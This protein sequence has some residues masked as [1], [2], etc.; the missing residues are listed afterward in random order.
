MFVKQK[1]S[2]LSHCD[3]ALEKY[4]SHTYFL[5][6]NKNLFYILFQIY[7]SEVV[8]AKTR[9]ACL[10]FVETI[11]VSGILFMFGLGAIPNFPYYKIALIPIGISALFIVTFMWIPESPRWLLL[12]CCDRSQA[13]SVLKYIH[14]PQ[15]K[16]EIE[17]ILGD[18]ETSATERT[19][20]FR[21]FRLLFCQ[22]QMLVP[23]IIALI[24]VAMQQ[25]CGIG[26][27]V[28]Y[29][30]QIFRRAGDQN[31]NF[32]AFFSAGLLFPL[33]TI[34]VVF[35]VEF[36]GRKLLLIASTAG[37]CVASLML[38]FQYYFTRPSLCLN[39]TTLEILEL[40]N[41]EMYCNPHL[42]PLSV[43]SVVLFS[44]SFEFGVGPMA[45]VIFSEYVPMQVKGLAGGIILAANR[46]AG[47]ILTGTYFTFSM[48]AGDYVVWWMLA[49]INFASLVF[50]ILFAIETK[51]KDLE[52]VPELFRK[53]FRICF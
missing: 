32:T 37:M 27:V 23:F 25:L 1:F 42:F 13:I 5:F 44:I 10:T 45:W 49:V 51:G 35:L 14:G 2:T 50:I 18:I 12:N 20:F 52:E 33:S 4:S 22:K 26:I 47:V 24:V 15:N 30:A 46:I 36:T 21:L 8:P 28:A 29:A 3:T 17:K 9:G 7:I 38:G 41:E 43:A 48:W 53:K 16:E 19:S 6:I 34:P 31:P 39:S 11:G 40:T